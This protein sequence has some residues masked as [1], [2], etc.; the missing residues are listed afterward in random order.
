MDKLDFLDGETLSG[1]EV[2]AEDTAA[3][4]VVEAVV[5]EVAQP[6]PEAA[7]AAATPEA[8]GAEAKSEAGDR[9]GGNIPITALL[10]E[11]EKRQRAERERD[12]LKR[13]TEQPA[14]LPE[15][16][17]VYDTE[18]YAKWQAEQTVTF[19]RSAQLD[20]QEDFAREKH[21]DEVVE[22]AKV[23]AEERVKAN[24]AFFPQMMSQRNPWA[25]VVAE[26]Q[27]DK[28]VGSIDTSELE[29]F[30][31]WQAAQTQL[32]TETAAPAATP[33]P[34]PAAQSAPRS[35]V[36][37]PSAGGAAHVVTGDGT[38]FDSVFNR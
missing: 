18:A 37:L 16:P 26:Y 28:L 9:E 14:Q 22:Q 13:L 4:V 20:V 11:R 35:I 23:W 12:E 34:T 38:A 29:K 8:T 1:E 3:D 17:D 32:A 25:Y 6:G 2:R 7:V 31:Q 33:T 5:E 30:R 27:R 19:V 15:P 24:P 21:G 36:A 10:D